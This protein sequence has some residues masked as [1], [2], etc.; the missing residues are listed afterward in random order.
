MRI[1]GVDGFVPYRAA[2]TLLA[3]ALS[4]PPSIGGW[5]PRCN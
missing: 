1:G 5:R 3:T 4:P 2:A